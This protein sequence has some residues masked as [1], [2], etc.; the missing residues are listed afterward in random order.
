MDH[1]DQMITTNRRSLITGLISLVA[2]PA[3]V[4]ASSL[5]PI[6][7]IKTDVTV[8]GLDPGSNEIAMQQVYYKGY[9]WWITGIDKVLHYEK[10]DNPFIFTPS[11]AGC[12]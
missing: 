9:V 8:L 6:K 11:L 2:A 4:R 10:C 5:M 7:A 3:I 1:G 12:L